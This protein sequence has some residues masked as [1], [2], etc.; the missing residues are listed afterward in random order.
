MDLND[1]Q[2]PILLAGTPRSGSTWAGKVLASADGR[3]YIHE[4][5]NEKLHP[6]AYDLKKDLHRYPYLSMSGI[7]KGYE[8]LW[9]LIFSGAAVPSSH[10]PIRRK[11][12]MP[13]PEILEHQ[14]AKKCGLP[15]ESLRLGNDPEWAPG[16]ESELNKR[17][18]L[19]ESKGHSML[20]E[21]VRGPLVVKSVH[22]MLSLP[23][24]EKHFDPRIVVLLRN[25]LNVIASYLRMGIAD[26]TRNIFNQGSILRDYLSEHRDVIQADENT[27][28]QMA[29]QI[30]GIYK[31]IEE[32]IKAHPRWVVVRHEDL[33]RDPI[34]AYRQL[35]QRLDLE[36]TQRVV[37]VI[38]ASNRPGKG[39]VTQR[40]A[41]DEVDKWQTELTPVQ[42]RDIKEIIQ[43]FNLSSY[44][45]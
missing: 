6:L 42:T 17:L 22:A 36:W 15:T 34:G 24:I 45:L 16:T 4:P 11:D 43:A 20:S 18:P 40:I 3:R 7:H 2:R 14:V 25:P 26:A 37:D 8:T 10:D 13:S 32:Q 39:F 9:Q 35:Y 30:G 5:D 31:V 28:R 27:V 21:A 12:V 23:W 1:H 29:A 44:D 38:Q 41:Q 33:C 19:V